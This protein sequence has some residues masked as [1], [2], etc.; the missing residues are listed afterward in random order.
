[1]PKSPIPAPGLVFGNYPEQ[2]AKDANYITRLQQLFALPS[3]WLGGLS[4]KRYQAFLQAV[5]L[6]ASQYQPL[7]TADFEAQLN[8]VRAQ[9]S[10]HGLTETTLTQC[11]ALVKVACQASLGLNPYDTQLLAARILVDGHLAE[12]A[13]GE[14]K[15]LAM[16]LGA[17]VM[18]IAGAPVHLITANDYLVNRDAMQL[19][20]LYQ[21]LGL[22]VG[23]VTQAHD[24][25]A[26][27]QAYA[28]DITYVTAKELTFDYLR[29]QAMGGAE[30]TALQQHIAHLSGQKSQRI[31]RGLCVALIDEADSILLDEARVPLILSRSVLQNDQLSYHSK[32]MELASRLSVEQDFTLHSAQLKAS[33]TAQGSQK[34]ADFSLHLSQLLHNRMHR[35]E[36]IC[37]ALAAQYLYH[38]DQHYLVHQNK[39]HIIDEIT[40]RLAVGRVWSQGLHQMIEL[41]EGC[42]T[43]A[44]TVTLS[45]ITYQRFFQRYLRLAGMSGTLHEDRIEL[46]K[47]YDL[48][49]IKVP[50]RTPS[51]RKI[52]PTRLYANQTMLW[53]YVIKQVRALQAQGRPVLIGT[54]SVNDSEQLSW[55]L[56]QAQITHQVL[57]ARQDQHEAKLIAQAGQIGQVTVSTNM[58]G[59]GTDI[60]LAPEV[61][62][63]GGLHVICVQ[64]NVSKRIDRQLLGRAAR[65]GLPGSVETVLA[66]DQT[67]MQNYYSARLLSWLSQRINK[68]KAGVWLSPQCLVN[69]CIRLP[70]SFAEA[71]QRAQ[72]FAMLKQ[73]QQQDE[74]QYH[75]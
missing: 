13:T 46:Y 32:A 34:I 9:F 31:L 28:R 47:M 74:A 16:G 56:T 24:T 27:K 42:Q 65:Q 72:R 64:H 37:Q 5:H 75:A 38:R 68:N 35:E 43:S 49:L 15:S 23:M 3:L 67:L 4:P 54:N 51:Q 60:H 20:P 30:N 39:I 29:D 6:L 71:E 62:T 59:R 61:I 33:L 63:Q 69:L 8:A 12:M 7:T 41:K 40:G 55:Q 1:M 45:Q 36:T 66:L 18:A 53:Q 73:D 10:M 70:Q 17:A 19:L 2:P 22:S 26:R 14:G 21:H 52:L 50:L 44:Q 58:A 57:N 11:F 48:R 25:Q